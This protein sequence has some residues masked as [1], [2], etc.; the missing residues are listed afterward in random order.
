M[1]SA[2]AL[3]AI[4]PIKG[5]VSPIKAIAATA[6]LMKTEMEGTSRITRPLL[7][8]PADGLPTAE[9]ATD[10]SRDG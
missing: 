4:N 6:R 1:V 5:A 7:G 9:L 10:P 3:G 2:C 8:V